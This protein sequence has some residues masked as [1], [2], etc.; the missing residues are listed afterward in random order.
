MPSRRTYL[1][2]AGTLPFLFGAGCTSPGSSDQTT[3][4]S[5]DTETSATST[6]PTTTPPVTTK[7]ETTAGP[8]ETTTGSRSF[9]FT[10]T[11]DDT[12]PNEG[13]AVSVRCSKLKLYGGT[14]HELKTYDV[15]GPSDDLAF[16]GAFDPES[17][18]GRTWRE[19]GEHVIVRFEDKYEDSEYSA[20]S[21]VELTCAT[22][23]TDPPINGTIHAGE[24][25][26]IAFDK[27]G[28]NEYFFS[29]H[30]DE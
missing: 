30:G 1:R 4:E 26:T 28:W 16:D 25:H 13:R 6:A 23:K 22:M 12:V 9:S 17:S 10:L 14:G 20:F 24:S 27:S 8:E 19:F 3:G 7:R 2:H 5:S 15:G 29:F 21:G 11:F 18:D